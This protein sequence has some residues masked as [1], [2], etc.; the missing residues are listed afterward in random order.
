MFVIERPSTMVTTRTSTTSL[1][2]TRNHLRALLSRVNDQ[3]LI[4][5]SCTLFSGF[6]G[7]TINSNLI[8]TDLPIM[9]LTTFACMPIFWTKGKITRAEGFILLNIYG[10]EGR[11]PTESYFR[12]IP[13]KFHDF[14]VNSHEIH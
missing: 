4:L 14:T 3:L 1:E 7:L 5:G 9:V 10:F 8:R 12:N 6:E 13:T 11:I 2:Q